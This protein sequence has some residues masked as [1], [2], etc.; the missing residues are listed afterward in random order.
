MG[1]LK[2]GA[3]LIYE[4]DNGTVYSRELGS[5]P[6]TRQVVGWDYVPQQT[7]QWVEEQ[8]HD[9]AMDDKMWGDIHREARTNITLRKALDCA[10]MIY[11]LSKDKV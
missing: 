3:T 8:L 2:P 5:C 11:K 6:S 10:I 9:N 1:N 4:R 7:L